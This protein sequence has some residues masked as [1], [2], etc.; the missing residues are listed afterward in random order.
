[1][2][3]KVLHV[4][5]SM[6]PGGAEVLLANSL[7]PGGLCEHTENHLAFF[8]APSYLTDQLDEKVH[9][10]F[11][12][13][14]GG[15]HIIRLLRQLSTIIKKNKIDIVHSHLNPAGT[16]VH[17]A[18]PKHIPHVHTI[19]TTYSMD[20]ETTRLK[21]WTEKNIYL[22]SRKSNLIFLS[23]FTKADFLQHVPF[24]G[25][26]FILNNFVDDA[27]FELQRKTQPQPLQQLK[28]I[29]IGSLRPVKNF[30]YLIEVFKYLKG[31]PI[32]LDIYGRGNTEAYEK[33]ITENDLS[34]T[35]KGHS[36][37]LQEILTGYD[38]FIMPSKFE[39]FPLSVFE[40]MAAGV[41][42]MLSNIAPLKSIV[43]DNALYFNLDD[44]QATAG[45][46][47]GILQNKIDINCMADIAKL[48]A[49]K[50]AKRN[51]YIQQLL[52]IYGKLTIESDSFSV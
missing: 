28:L 10:H 39:G 27:F 25:N 47:G 36:S 42:L 29:A 49:T 19:H 16:Y 41:P 3:L 35:M 24:M 12:D 20:K 21:L 33:L 9:V 50:I 37:N 30:E 18:C 26:A 52:E 7:S 48:Y 4:I 2:K 38:L 40:A 31:L 15:T 1:M 14:K 22:K 43:K 8:M 6:C 13:Y 44:A 46:L 23:E 32:S 45:L 5:N 17:I 34:I 51:I 11:L